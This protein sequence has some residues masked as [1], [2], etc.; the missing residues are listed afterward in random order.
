MEIIKLCLAKHIMRQRNYFLL[1]FTSCILSILPLSII[2][3]RQTANVWSQLEFTHQPAV[4]DWGS[5]L[6]LQ[7]RFHND[8][9]PH[10]RSIAR[11][12]TAYRA[13]ANWELW[14]GS[15]FIPY[16]SE[17]TKWLLEQRLWQQVIWHVYFTNAWRINARLRIEERKNSN[18]SAWAY[19]LRE[20][21]DLQ[22]SKAWRGLLLPKCYVEAMLNLNK[23]TWVSDKIFSELRLF[24]G[25]NILFSNPNNIQLQLGYLWQYQYGRKHDDLAHI[26][27]LALHLAL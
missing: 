27:L 12:A 13:S 22:S 19:R 11:I 7:A 23:P 21:W 24:A 3:L 18:I 15:D 8:D 26:M 10:Y 6:D 25:V 4:H 5:L 17:D 14:A 9:N 16:L 2:A 20:R 1:F